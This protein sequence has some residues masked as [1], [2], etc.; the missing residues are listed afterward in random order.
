MA[1]VH[2]STKNMCDQIFNAFIWQ[3]FFFIEAEVYS[4]GTKYAKFHG[5]K[6]WKIT[7]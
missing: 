1:M 3:D 4:V 7:I 2:G 6:E 5:L